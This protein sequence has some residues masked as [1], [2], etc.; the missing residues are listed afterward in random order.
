MSRRLVLSGLL[1]VVVTLV[2]CQG[3]GGKELCPSASRP[4]SELRLADQ[5]EI[6]VDEGRIVALSP[7]GKWVVVA[8]ETE[9]CIC[10]VPSL[11]KK[12]CAEFGADVRLD[13]ISVAWSPDSKRVA[14]TENAVMYLYESDVWVLEVDSGDLKNLT[15]DGQVGSILSVEGEAAVDIAPAW[16]CD[17]KRLVFSHS[18]WNAEELD[19]TALYSVPASGGNPKKLLTV[20]DEQRMV[21]SIPCHFS[22]GEEKM[23]YTVASTDR[24][25]P[26]NGV[27]IAGEDGRDLRRLLGATDSEMGPPFLI[28]A[29]S[30]GD[31]VLV[32][33]PLGDAQFSDRFNMC[34]FALVDLQS[35]TTEP[36]KK[37]KGDEIEFILVNDATLSP[38]GSKVLYVYLDANR[39]TR[40]AV[41]DVD[42]DTENI[43][44]TDN[45]MGGFQAGW[46][47]Y[48]GVGLDW[49]QTDTIYVATHRR[50]VL[51][52]SLE[53][54]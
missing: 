38:D 5:R 39:E 27:W 51:L 7:D 43:L 52:L 19:G 23:L 12:C 22:C 37:A 46:S 50:S 54:D 9:L 10:E 34:L 45:G 13:P 30:E 32:S 48:L 15:D 47:R 41:R 21:V 1:L 16:T 6:A 18:G 36:V 20:D 44:L 29:S 40:L 14:F 33:Y 28:D 35:G 4:A 8:K 26:D 31:K 2:G 24:D 3:S 17:G 49:A 42:G 11:V 53:T 25:D